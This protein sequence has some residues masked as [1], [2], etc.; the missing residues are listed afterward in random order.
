MTL[1]SCQYKDFDELNDVPDNETTVQAKFIFDYSKLGFQPKVMRLVLYPLD[2]QFTNPMI[3]DVKDS[4]TVKLL[5][6]RYGAVAFNEDN[7]ILLFSGYNTMQGNTKVTT[8]YA[9]KSRLALLDTLTNA[10]FYDFPERTAVFYCD[11]IRLGEESTDSRAVNIIRNRITFVPYE[12]TRNVDVRIEGMK[13]MQYLTSVVFCLDGCYTEY[14]I[15]E[16][17]TGTATGFIVSPDF[18]VDLSDSI[19]SGNYYIFG[20]SPI[21]RHTLHVILG[22]EGF[23]HVL[24]FDLIDNV[25]YADNGFDIQIR[26]QSDFDVYSLVPRSGGFN[27]DVHDWTT[28][29][30]DVKL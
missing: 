29:S 10:V 20:L 26:L 30:T 23:S 22:G 9:D 1:V 28:D 12:T 18:K 5:K 25:K 15:K 11:S 21:T 2:G 14:Y 13:N 3:R 17:S 4:I 16:K 8:G 19:L 7:S 24:N 27:L 6:G